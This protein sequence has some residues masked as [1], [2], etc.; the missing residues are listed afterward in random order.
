MNASHPPLPRR[1]RPRSIRGRITVLVTALATVLL[2]PTGLL[3]GVLAR[4]AFDTAVWLDAQQEAALTAAAWRSGH[5]RHVITPQV[6]GISLVQ[7]VAPN[8]RVLAAS[9]AARGKPPLSSFWPPQRDPIR[10]LQPCVHDGLGCLR[11]SALRVS[12]GPD[13]PVVYAGRRIDGF[14]PVAMFDLLFTVEVTALVLLTAWATWKV[15]GRTL[16]PVEAIRSDLAAVNVN[17]LDIRVPVPSGDDEIARLARTVNSTLAR[18]EQAKLTTERALRR[19]R[20]FA[21]DA[22]HELRTPLAGLRAQLEEAQLHPDETDLRS[23]LAASLSDVERL[24]AIIDDLLLLAKVGAT[25]PDRKPVDV[26]ELVRD[27]V[28]R[29]ADRIP[30]RLRLEDGVRMHAAPRHLARLLTNLLDNAQRHARNVVEIGL[31]RDEGF[32]EL[33]VGD[34]GP[35][36]P[37]RERERI[38]ER[39]ARSD[40]ARS[41]GDGGAGLGLAIARDIA[42]AHCGTLVAAESPYGGAE[43]VLRL[44]VSGCPPN[45]DGATAQSVNRRAAGP[46]T[47]LSPLEKAPA[48]VGDGHARRRSEEGEPVPDGLPPASAEG[49]HEGVSGLHRGQPAR[50][51]GADLAG[52]PQTEREFL[53]R[54]RPGTAP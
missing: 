35:G 43:F 20:E 51:D 14:T 31:R 17:D 50:S 22:S 3:G 54:D 37:V 12:P 23:L 53:K 36:V 47:E 8:R 21:A 33:R 24:E 41:R 49:H 1:L 16:R 11:L 45:A 25:A 38:F 39:F 29:R 19:Q 32:V 18:I 28:T 27:E 44:P 5:L 30:V 13:S 6:A 9:A 4:R 10:D 48:P 15:A 52:Q 42:R 2:I 7:V 26:T 34:D 46:Y 40:T